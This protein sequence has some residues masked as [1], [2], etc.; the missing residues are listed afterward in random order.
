MVTLDDA[1]DAL[2]FKPPWDWEERVRERHGKR[3]VLDMPYEG[4][5]DRRIGSSL[6]ML[7]ELYLDLE[8]A[9]RTVPVGARSKIKFCVI[10]LNKQH[11][12]GLRSHL[13]FLHQRLNKYVSLEQVEFTLFNDVDGIRGRLFPSWGVFCD[14]SVKEAA[15][16]L[17]RASGPYRYIRQIYPDPDQPNIFSCFDRD[18]NLICQTFGEEVNAILKSA[19]CPI[20]FAGVASGRKSMRDIAYPAWSENQF[21]PN[22]RYMVPFEVV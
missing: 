7:I 4:D 14:H 3:Y 12:Q 10:C 18:D 2:G 16:G 20:V 6:H 13:A 11:A 1:Y 21:Q 8:K 17:E 15:I 22:L 5:T 19:E 9:N